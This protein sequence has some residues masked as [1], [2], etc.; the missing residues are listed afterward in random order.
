M[1]QGLS[2]HEVEL[3]RKNGQSNATAS[4][5][6]RSYLHIIRK[7]VF[8]FVNIVLVAIGVLLVV[9]SSPS[10]AITTAGLVVVNVLTGVV[11]EIR[12]KR[13]LDQ[14]TLLT[15]PRVTVIRDGQEHAIDASEIVLGDVVAVNPGD[16]IVCDGR[17][18]GDSP[19]EVDESLLTGESDYILKRDGDT[20]YS[21]SFCVSGSAHYETTQVGK[22][23][24]A[25]TITAKARRFE[26]KLTPLQH[27]VNAIVRIVGVVCVILGGLLY[28][29]AAYVDM[30]AVERVQILAVIIGTIPQGLIFL[31]TLSYALGA[32]RLAGQGVLV[33]QNNAVESLSNITV[34]CMDKT[35]TLTTN[36]IQFEDV[37]PYDINPEQ[38]KHLLSEM[39]AS[40]STRNR[41]SDALHAALQGQPLQLL[42]ELPF[43]SAHKWS[44]L[45][46]DAGSLHGAYILGAQEIVLPD[47]DLIAPELSEQSGQWSDQG[48]R[49]ILFAHVA[50]AD[51]LRDSADKPC[52]PPDLKPLGIVALSD[53]QREG[54]RATLDGFVQT[55][56]Q[57]KII[58]GDSPRTVAA[59]AAQVGFDAGSR[60][61][62]GDELAAL[63][64]PEFVQA[65]DDNAIFGRIKPDQKEQLMAALRERGAYVAMI[66]DGVNDVLALKKSH[67]GIAMNSGSA[68]TRNVADIILLNDS[69]AALPA[70]FQEGQRI[71][72]GILDTMRLLL[73]RTVYVLSIVLLTTLAGATFPFLPTQ[74]ALNS[75]LTAG[76]PPVLLALWAISGNPPQPILRA[77][78]RFVFPA[79][80]TIAL[81]GTGVYLTY[82]HFTD[83]TTAQAALVTTVIACGA[84]LILFAKPPHPFFATVVPLSQDR[85]PIALVIGV[86][87]LLALILLLSPLRTFFDLTLLALTDYALIALVVLIWMLGLHLISRRYGQSL[88]HNRG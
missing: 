74:D 78:Q 70:V 65:A 44:G 56:I 33:Q 17:V 4:A 37:A 23:S 5:P 24:L 76:L 39:V 54:A 27:N 73:T 32:L 60:L 55:G 41:T 57:I 77:V 47:L 71:V 8:T 72:N 26:V 11:Q 63:D 36:R 6:S 14:I 67:I 35:G 48:L 80:A 29:R 88:H 16:Q 18:L 49:V 31:V 40:M 68:I 21:G 13:K 58:S 9:L 64:W 3:R 81:A 66:G 61:I 50:H 52:L 25:N 19:F 62:T 69:F 34:L 38:F 10:D 30:P 87:G 45:I 75:F 53:E 59:L 51:A 28:A 12:A 86:L 7:N 79:A 1:I 15:R 82:L 20:V 22:N 42:E 2:Q 85:R 46:A 84:M 43:A 83:F